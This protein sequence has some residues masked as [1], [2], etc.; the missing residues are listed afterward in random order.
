MTLASQQSTPT[1]TEKAQGIFSLNRLLFIGLA[2]AGLG[3]LAISVT[4]PWFV[5]PIAPPSGAQ[6]AADM[7][8]SIPSCTVFFQSLVAIGGVCIAASWFWNRRWSMVSTLIASFL[9]VL[10][11]LYPYFVTVRSPNVSADAAWLQMQHD[12]LTWLGGDIYANAEYGAKGWKSKTYLVDA[13]RQLAVI[14]LPSWSPWEFGLHRTQD[15]ML[16]LGYSNAFCQFVGKGWAL[17]V[18]GAVLLLLAS[19]QCCGEL[20]LGRAGAAVGLFTSIAFVSAIVGWSLPFKASQEIRVAAEFCGKQ[21][22]AKAKNHLERAV[23]LLPVLGQDTYYV[24]QRGVLDQRLNI[25][26]DYAELQKSN[27]LES[28][29][30][31]DQAFT[32]L[33]RLC[34]SDESAVRREAFRGILRFA[35]QDYNCARFESSSDRFSLVLKYYPCDVKVIYLLQLQGIRESRAQSVDEM[36]D[37]MYAASGKFNFGTK[38][39]LRAVAQQHAAI[40]VGLSDDP[41]AIWAGQSK[42][43]SP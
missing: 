40:V 30:R 15:L 36:R 12:N 18:V 1:L 22:Y 42:A 7:V 41:V 43:K 28:A 39:A 35:I 19:L 4:R 23:E 13:P 9:C 31:F 10:P 8:D 37:W 3:A 33:K 34:D 16:W 11:L 25:E 6:S 20:I 38:K 26:S 24:A 2:W 5:V 27:R 17:A 29:G 32:I 14:N 21:E